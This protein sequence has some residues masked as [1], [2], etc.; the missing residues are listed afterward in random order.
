MTK[1]IISILV[2]LTSVT[3]GAAQDWCIW[4]GEEYIKEAMAS[5]TENSKHWLQAVY[6]LHTAESSADLDT[7]TPI[8]GVGSCRFIDRSLAE[9]PQDVINEYVKSYSVIIA[10]RAYLKVGASNEIVI[11]EA[12]Y[13]AGSNW[14]YVE[15]NFYAMDRPICEKQKAQMIQLGKEAQGIRF[16][17]AE[18]KTNK[19]GGVSAVI[20]GNTP[21]TNYLGVCHFN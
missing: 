17:D 4:D 12:Y 15:K 21:G 16:T 18:Y 9:K 13:S 2:L 20:N 10:T 19:F 7:A 11:P 5:G 8:E 14:I 6:E 3:A 1:K